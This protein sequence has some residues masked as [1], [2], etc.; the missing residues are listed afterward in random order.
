MPGEPGDG[1]RHVERVLAVEPAGAADQPMVLQ[2]G[3]LLVVDARGLEQVAPAD[4][5]RPAAGAGLRA[6]VIRP[7]SRPPAAG[8]G[9]AMLKPLPDHAQRQVVITLGGEDEPQPGDVIRAEPPVAGGRP[10]RADQPLGFQEADLGDADVRELGAQ[11]DKHLAD[12]EVCLRK[13]AAHPVPRGY[14]PFAACE[15][16]PCK[17]TS[18]NLP[19]CTSS[20]ALSITSSIRSRLT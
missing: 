18:L 20:P 4:H 15:R 7:V 19:I 8:T 13:L 2:L 16:R 6:R 12:A 11:L 5:L 3:E 9:L 17:K 10:S 1:A 14:P